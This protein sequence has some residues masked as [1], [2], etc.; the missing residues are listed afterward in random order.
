M[1]SD[2]I[3]YDASEIITQN[4]PIEKASEEL[5]DL[6]VEVCNGKQVQAELLGY[7]ETAIQRASV[8]V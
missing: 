7:T 1:M 4:K 8:F 5:L 3:D 6:I 2:N